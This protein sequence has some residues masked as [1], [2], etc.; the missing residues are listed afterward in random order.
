MRRMSLLVGAII[1]WIVPIFVAHSIGKPK[2]REGGY[3]GLLLGWIGVLVIAILPPLAPKGGSSH[4][5]CPF[6][7]EPMRV[8]ASV[9]PHCRHESPALAT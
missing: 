1:L 7:K 8:D 9:C 3:Y 2:R 5:E 6:C 4:R